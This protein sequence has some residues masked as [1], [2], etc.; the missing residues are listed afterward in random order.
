[1]A[2]AF[3]GFFARARDAADGRPSPS[4]A[5]KTIS[6]L[7]SPP[8][9]DGLRDGL[10]EWLRGP[11]VDDAR[12]F[13]RFEAYARERIAA[14]SAETRRFAVSCNTYIARFGSWMQALAD[15]QVRGLDDI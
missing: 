15:P 12:R 14:D 10:R 11:H 2:R 4:V 6:R 7:G 8:D 1:V 9:V 5:G 13:N 3:G